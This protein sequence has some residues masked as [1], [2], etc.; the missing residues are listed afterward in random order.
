MIDFVTNVG[1]FAFG[2]IVL[3]AT[4]WAVIYLIQFIRAG[5]HMPD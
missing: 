3:A 5:F 1:G 2:I 4:A